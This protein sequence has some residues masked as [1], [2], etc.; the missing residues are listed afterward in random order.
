MQNGKKVA[1]V[2]SGGGI[3]GPLQVGAL[4]S[5][6]KHGIEPDMFVGTSAGALNSGFMASHGPTLDS[7]PVLKDAWHSAPRD[8]VDPGNIFTIAGR[9]VSGDDGLFPTRQAY[10]QPVHRVV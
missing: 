10:G 9:L 3:R 4:E 7:I 2:L 8:V 1:V 6:L 5:L